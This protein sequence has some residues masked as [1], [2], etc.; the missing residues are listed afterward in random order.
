MICDAAR[1]PIALGRVHFLSPTD[2]QIRFMAVDPAWTG[3]GL[4][5]R[6]LLALERRAQS[7]G[8][9]QIVLNARRPAIPFYLKHQYIIVGSAETLFGEVEHVRMEKRLTS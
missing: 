9:N 1:I 7:R 3:R 2:A 5:G 6:I 4:G 8:A